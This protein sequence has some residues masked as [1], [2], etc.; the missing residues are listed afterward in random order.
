M[1]LP[2]PSVL[3]M[4]A[5]LGLAAISG[6]LAAVALTSTNADVP[7]KTVTLNLENGPTGPTGPAGP[8]GDIGPAG[9]KGDTGPQGPAGSQDCPKGSTFSKLVLNAPGGQTSIYTCIVD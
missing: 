8:K 3:L 6:S 1:K 9:P 2:K 4:S 5:S 7:T